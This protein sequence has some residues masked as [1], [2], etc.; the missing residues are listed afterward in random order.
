[1]SNSQPTP[2]TEH[3][4]TSLEGGVYS[5]RFNRP[6]KKNAL[7]LAMY[8]ALCAALKDAS[9]RPEARVLCLSGNG[10]CF[11]SGNDLA[12]FAGN[13]PTGEDSPVFRYLLALAA[14]EKPLVAAV[15]GVAV[16]VGVTMLLHFDLVY[17]SDRA[18]FSLP[19]INLAVVPEGASTLLLPARAGALLANELFLFGEPFD[20]ATAQSARLVNKVVPAAQLAPHVQERCAALAAKPRAAVAATKKLLR[21][22]NGD[23]VL[24]TLRREGAIFMERVQSPEALEAFTAFFEKRKPDFSKL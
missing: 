15:D 9:E 12:D 8:D 6:Q 10:E 22:A 19:F 14:F 7:T 24:A 4:Q 2:Q 11:T 13:P 21:E 23:A 16:G 5:V 20:A 17:A 3:L 1:M 18:R